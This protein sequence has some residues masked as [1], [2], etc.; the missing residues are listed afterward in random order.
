MEPIVYRNRDRRRTVLWSVAFFLWGAIS[1][2]RL[3][4]GTEPD[5]LHVLGVAWLVILPFVLPVSFGSIA[6]DDMGITARRVIRRRYAWRDISGITV[7]ERTGRGN[8]AYRIVLS[9]PGRRPRVLPAPYVDIRASRVWY[10]ELLTQAEQLRARHRAALEAAG[11]TDGTDSANG[12]AAGGAA[13]DG[14]EADGA[15]AGRGPQVV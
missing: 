3:L 10:E 6:V 2:A 5:F 15:E 14:T 9:R 1:L 8:G 13:V 12:A 7:E 4:R 11:G